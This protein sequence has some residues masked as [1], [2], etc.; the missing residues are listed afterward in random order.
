MNINISRR[1]IFAAAAVIML[2]G[3]WHGAKVLD[4]AV[5][6][7]AEVK[8]IASAVDSSIPIGQLYLKTEGASPANAAKILLNGYYH[9]DLDAPEMT[10]DIPNG[11][12]VE[13]DARGLAQP[14]TVTI[15]GK[16]A[17]VVTECSGRSVEAG[18]RIVN[19]GT[20]VVRGAGE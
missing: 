17:G 5:T 18:G 6:T 10:V 20:F 19:L 11:C 13:I 2:I 4:K 3:G 8:D 15:T 14:I 1:L 12:V 9:D 7:G 16:S